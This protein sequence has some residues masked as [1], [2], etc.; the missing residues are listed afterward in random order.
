M[1]PPP[2][3]AGQPIFAILILTVALKKVLIVEDEAP[4]AENLK[5]LFELEG[6]A[7]D[8]AS[9]LKTAVEKVERHY[10]PLVVL[11]LLLPDGNGMEL[12]KHLNLKRTKVIVLTAHGT[13]ETAV[14]AVKRGAFDFLQKPVSFKKLRQLCERAI[15]ELSKPSEEG[16]GKET[17]RGLIG[18]SPFIRELKERLSQIAAENKNVLIRGE[19][20]VGKTF[21]GELIHKL[22][23]RRDFPLVKVAVAGKG[24]FELEVELFGSSLPGRE[25][26]G[27]LERAEGGTLILAGV[28]HMPLS[29]QRKLAQAIEARSYT[30][31]GGNRRRYLNVRFISTTSKNLYEMAKERKF[32]ENLLVKLNEIELEIPP[33]RERRED[34]LPLLEHF[35]ELFSKE[36]GGVKPILSEEVKE[37]LKRYE[38][39]AN[40]RELKNLAERL[41]LLHRGRIVNVEDLQLSPK[42]EDRDNLFSIQ[43]WREAKRSFE[44]EFLKRKLIETGG[45]IK[46]VAKLINLD[47]SNIYRKIREYHLEEYVKNRSS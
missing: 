24:E 8:T 9:D 31:V 43:N 30:P 47:I 34:I 35:I 46:E 19:E 36:S 33:L 15:Q 42:R 21:A 12:L 37:F 5:A 18:N 38:F 29:V 27:A 1:I 41:V 14:E 6:Y 17:L 25:R 32:D 22:S 16:E 20:G 28:E 2:R 13:I 23:P 45:N 40:V 10:Y 3:P 44:K 11:D 7:A 39:P 4:T 26:V